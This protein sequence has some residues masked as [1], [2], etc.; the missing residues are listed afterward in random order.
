MVLG[1]SQ[2]LVE[3]AIVPQWAKPKRP[4]WV[5]QMVVYPRLFQGWS[6]FAPDPPRE[7]GW[8]IVDGRTKDGR[9]LDPLTGK[10]PNFS[11]D[12]PGGPDFSPQWGA[13]HMRIF[14][15]RFR[16]YYN[17]MRDYLLRTHEISGRPQDQLVAFDAWYLS[18][19]VA[20][21]G[22]QPGAVQYRKLFGY[23]HITDSGSPVPEVAPQAPGQ[24]H[25][26]RSTPATGARPPRPAG[27]ARPGVHSPPARPHPRASAHS[28]GPPP[29]ARP[30]PGVQ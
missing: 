27:S 9:K 3:N 6:M 21:P 20:D 25:R 7:D 30:A 28:S 18:R 16:V 13:F 22:G 12:L 11:M 15:N 29:P 10:E 4:D 1:T 2:I 14:E 17:G 8:M 19:R 24:R 5:V 23:G 26:P